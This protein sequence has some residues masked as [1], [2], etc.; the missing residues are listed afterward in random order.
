MKR[1]DSV[2]NAVYVIAHL[3][4]NDEYGVSGKLKTNTKFYREI[5]TS[6]PLQ[7]IKLLTTSD[8]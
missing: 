8:N 4:D 7:Y 2:R 6:A 3:H 5:I 1:T